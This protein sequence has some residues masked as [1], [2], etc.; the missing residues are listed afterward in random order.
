MHLESALPETGSFGYSF[1]AELSLDTP[2]TR[3]DGLQRLLPLRVSE[4]TKTLA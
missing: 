2:V 4:R 3:G 1:F